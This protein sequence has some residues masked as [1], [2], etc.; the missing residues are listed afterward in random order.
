MSHS[1]GHTILWDMARKSALDVTPWV[2]ELERLPF[3]R[4]VRVRQANGTRR[5]R[6][7]AGPKTFEYRLEVRLAQPLSR[8]HVAPLLGAGSRR[9][10]R[11][12]LFAPHVGASVGEALR[13]R[14]VDYVDLA[15]N[16]HIDADGVHMAHVEGRRPRERFVAPG[17]RQRAAHYGVYFALAARPELAS[18]TVR[19]IAR[20]AGAGKSTVDRTLARLE[21]DGV[22]ASTRRG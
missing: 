10:E 1:M 19:E 21:A 9:R 4:D 11:V 8:A 17:E 15:G 12:L 18:A 22:V 6:L 3:V 20:H 5:V 14:G 7:R 13:E 2:A 16:C